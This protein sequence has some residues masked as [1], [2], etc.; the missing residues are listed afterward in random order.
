MNRDTATARWYRRLDPAC[1]TDQSPDSLYASSGDLV[2]PAFA[3]P[4]D[5]WATTPTIMTTW[6]NPAP[7]ADPLPRPLLSAV[8]GWLSLLGS[9]WRR[10]LPSPHQP[11]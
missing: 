7:T 10:P 9:L 3:A 4:A 8:S 1:F 5:R 2:A 11:R 6:G